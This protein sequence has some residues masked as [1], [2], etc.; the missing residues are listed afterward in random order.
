MPQRGPGLQPCAPNLGPI[1]SGPCE[2]PQASVGLTSL[3]REVTLQNDPRAGP[4]APSGLASSQLPLAARRFLS[5]LWLLGQRSWPL[6]P[7]SPGAPGRRRQTGGHPGPCRVLLV[8]WWRWTAPHQSVFWNRGGGHWGR[9]PP[10]PLCDAGQLTSLSEPQLPHLQNEAGRDA[11][12]SLSACSHSV[13]PSPATAFLHTP[14]P[15]RLQSSRQL[16]EW[17]EGPLVQGLVGI[18]RCSLGAGW[19]VGERPCI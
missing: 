17:T 2:E 11:L 16:A 6:Q 7:S 5:Q 13:P 4:W 18:K 10:S 14:P 8:R 15:R 19:R 12:L 3:S 9:P 1:K